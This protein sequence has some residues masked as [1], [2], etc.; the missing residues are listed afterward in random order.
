MIATAPTLTHVLPSAE[1]LAVEG[2]EGSEDTHGEDELH[3]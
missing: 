1:L 2:I 3:L